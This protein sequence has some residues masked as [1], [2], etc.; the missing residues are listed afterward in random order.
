MS[1]AIE[2]VRINELPELTALPD[3]G[4]LV[5]YDAAADVTYRVAQGLIK[6]GESQ[7][8]AWNPSEPWDENE[9]VIYGLKLWQSLSDANTGNVP[10][11]GSIYWVEVSPSENGYTPLWAAGVFTRNQ[12]KVMRLNVGDDKYY[13]YV[14]RTP[15]PFTSSD[16]DA[17]LANGDWQLLGGA[18]GGGGS[19][20]IATNA[21]MDAGTNDTK[22]VS[23]L[24][25]VYGITTRTF[26]ALK[27]T[28]KSIQG[29]INELWDKLFLKQTV[30]VGVCESCPILSTDV[31]RNDAT[32]TLTIATIKG[33]E[34]ISASNP[35]R[36]FT[37]GGGISVM[38][39]KATAQ[40]VTW[41]DTKGLKYI[42]FDTDGVLKSSD[43]PWQFG[44]IA[45]VWRLYWNPALTGSARIVR[46]AIEYHTNTISAV[47][48]RWKHRYGAIW[49]SGFNFIANAITSGAPNASG[50]NTCISLTGGTNMDDNLP[51]T[52][53][54]STTPADFAQDL[55][56][57]TSANITTANAGVF[58][59]TYNTPDGTLTVIPGTRFPFH[60]IGDIPQVISAGG[61]ITPVVNKNF[62]NYY[63]YSFQDPRFGKVISLRS[64]GQYTTL[65]AAQ[66]E[67]WE[68]IKAA[69]PTLQD[70]EVRQL[71]KGTWEFNTS[72]PISIKD[73]VLR[74]FVDLRQNAAI[75]VTASSGATLSTNVTLSTP[76]LGA[77]SQDE[78][79]VANVAYELEMAFSDETTAFTAS[80]TVPKLTKY[81]EKAFDCTSVVIDVNTAP[82]DSTA[83]FDV[84]KNGT[85]IF[86][87]YPSID[88]TEVT[89]RTAATPAVLTTSPTA[90]AIGDK[91][92]VF[93]RQIGSTIAGAGGKIALKGNK[94]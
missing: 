88:S 72:Y 90:F 76:L 30:F 82:T 18:G 74:S 65:A 9:V 21:D 70:G 93:V 12:S 16:F 28:A 84:Q 43:T 14:L 46:E 54:N 94:T 13:E 53:V 68:Q 87:T 75:S 51:Y 47:D 86:S 92:E 33:G 40:S 39:E 49:L 80:T 31:I 36:V 35:I 56:E 26:S 73:S 61:V 62:F 45:P 8:P 79:N 29:A 48:H 85:T 11:T 52:V 44:S 38:H 71:Y 23:P 32:R 41:S 59:I 89:T 17:E 83:I 78:Y 24:K 57:Q 91:I 69:S 37:D 20:D 67:T 66:G 5:L 6:G 64:G 58:D 42:Y 4:Y 63:I 10:A 50:L 81:V 19:V 77:T 60:F 3:V 22:A 7:V 34:T 15:A 1:Q 27:T 55:G 2:I 25:F